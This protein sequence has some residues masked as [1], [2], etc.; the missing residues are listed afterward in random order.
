MKKRYDEMSWIQF[1]WLAQRPALFCFML[2]GFLAVVG[3]S[4]SPKSSTSSETQEKGSEEGQSRSEDGASQANSQAA[5]SATDSESNRSGLSSRTDALSQA[6]KSGL[7]ERV[8]AEAGRRLLQNPEDVLALNA[9]AMWNFKQKRY[10][11]ARLLILKAIEKSTPSAAL[12]AN[13]GLILQAE[14]EA[15]LAVEQWKRALRLDEGNPTANFSLGTVYVKGGDYRR[16]TPLLRKAQ[17]A[18]S[19]TIDVAINLGVSLVGEGE[20]SDAD[21]V[22]KSAIQKYGNK[23]SQLLLNYAHLLVHHLNRPK[24]GLQLVYRIKLIET[25]RKDILKLAADLEAKALAAQ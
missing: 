21:R 12:H 7:T 23:D 20:Y 6:L 9:L 18:A 25:D 4:T 1:A 11:A 19:A 17:S 24:D 3:C 10:G 2:V 13:F 8:E 14:G 5:R 15:Q 16:A 22:F